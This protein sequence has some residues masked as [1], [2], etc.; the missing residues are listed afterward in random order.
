VVR[1]DHKGDDTYD[2]GVQFVTREEKN[3]TYIFPKVHFG[4]T[5]IDDEG[6]EQDEEQEVGERNEEEEGLPN[7]LEDTENEEN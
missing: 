3:M 5:S 1:I 2:I 4:K 7:N 6:D